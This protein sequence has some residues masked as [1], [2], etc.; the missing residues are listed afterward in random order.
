M[1]PRLDPDAEA[2][3]VDLADR[4]EARNLTTRIYVHDGM[5]I[6]LTHRDNDATATVDDAFSD[7]DEVVAE[8]AAEGAA[9]ERNRQ[10]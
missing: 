6:A 7:D 2:A 4:L 5:I 9:I 8:L 1:Q 10:R 3:L